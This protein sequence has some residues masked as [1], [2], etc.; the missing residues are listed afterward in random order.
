MC[1]L[2]NCQDTLK[3]VISP[4]LLD[5]IIALLCHDPVKSLN[6]EPVTKLLETPISRFADFDILARQEN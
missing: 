3:S 4:V 2:N 6:T 5:A 1:T